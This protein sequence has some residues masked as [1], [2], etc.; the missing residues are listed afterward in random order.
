MTTSKSATKEPKSTTGNGSRGVSGPPSFVKY[1]LSDD[2][3]AQAREAATTL[4]DVGEIFTQMISE[5]YKLS[6][7]HDGYGGGVQVFM[8]PTDPEGENAGW[9]LTARAP[10]LL[11]AV[12]VLAWKHY[13]LFSQKWPKVATE[14]KT[15]AWG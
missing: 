5:G 13:T 4:S 7:S 2:E 11:Q 14:T 9:T 10:F 6:A 12:G 3:M 15:G 1:R 8:T